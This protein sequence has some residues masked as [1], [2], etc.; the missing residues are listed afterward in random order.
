MASLVAG[1]YDRWLREQLK[2]IVRGARSFATCS[3]RPTRSRYDDPSK[4]GQA[5]FLVS[6]NGADAATE[7]AAE[8]SRVFLGI[9]IQCAQCHDHPSDIW[10]RQNFHEFAAY[11]ARPKT[12]PI[13]EEKKLV[14]FHSFPRRSAST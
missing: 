13:R 10:K 2:R 9:Q 12:R 7:L 8:T 3:W 11:F 5:F 4:N 6:R 1:H 14:G